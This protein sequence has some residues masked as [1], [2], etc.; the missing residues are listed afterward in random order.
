[1]SPKAIWVEEVE[2]EVRGKPVRVQ[3]P[4]VDPAQCN[5]CG[6]CEFVCPVNDKAAIRVTSAGES[7]SQTN[8]LLLGKTRPK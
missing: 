2:V 6:A 1:M 8:A 3:R 5:G 7:R 4:Y